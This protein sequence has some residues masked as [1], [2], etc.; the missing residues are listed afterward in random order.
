MTEESFC[1]A[2]D[3]EHTFV[4]KKA[5]LIKVEI[6]DGSQDKFY[7]KMELSLLIWTETERGSVFNQLAA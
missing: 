6:L 3:K 2:A 7:L 4:V 5:K 1:F